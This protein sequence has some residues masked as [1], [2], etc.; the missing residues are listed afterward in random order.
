VRPSRRSAPR[1]A[2][3]GV[4]GWLL[5]ALA[6]AATPTPAEAYEEQATLFVD[7]GYAA[8]LANEDLP[9]SGAQIGLGG[10]W[11][12]TDAWTIRGRLAYAA[13]PA[14]EVL[15]VGI[16]GVEVFYMLDIL[17]LVPF[18]GLGIDGIGTIHDGGSGTFFGADFAIHAVVGLDWLVSRR[19]IVGVDVRPYILPLSFDDDPLSPVYLSANVRLSIVFER[20]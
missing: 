17:E 3:P 18:A 6:L 13:H 5:A 14:S 20:Y 1:A 2:L 7:L 11:G 15:H 4:L 10:S 9:T 19:L 12:L 8:A 16:V